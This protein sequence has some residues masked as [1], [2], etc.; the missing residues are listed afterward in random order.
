[1][2]QAQASIRGRALRALFSSSSRRPRDYDD[3]HLFS[4]PLHPVTLRRLGGASRGPGE[5][6]E[7]HAGIP[8]GD[9][10]L[11]IHGGS[12]RRRRRD[13]EK[14]EERVRRERGEG[15]E[16]GQGERGSDDDLCKDE[17][18]LNASSRG[19]WMKVIQTTP[20]KNEII[21]TTPAKMNY[22]LTPAQD[23]KRKVLQF[24]QIR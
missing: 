9:P 6:G 18:D 24:Q 3:S 19:R 5:L 15:E 16:N 4:H 8:P 14:R 21:Q 22:Q 7:A 12:R 23:T 11:G 20:T 1:M 10:G 13:G 2:A 17:I